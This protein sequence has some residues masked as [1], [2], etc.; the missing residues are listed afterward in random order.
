MRGYKITKLMYGV[1]LFVLD[2]RSGFYK[3]SN[4]ENELM[5]LMDFITANNVVIKEVKTSN[6]NTTWKIGDRVKINDDRR[7]YLITDFDILGNKIVVYGKGQANAE[8]LFEEP[9]E[10]VNIYVEPVRTPVTTP[11][12]ERPVQNAV[13]IDAV[14]RQIEQ[15]NP[16]PIRLRGILKNRRETL[17]QFLVKFFFG[18]GNMERGWNYTKDTVYADDSSVQTDMGKRR[19]LGDIYMICKYYYPNVTLKE[20]LQQLY[21]ELPRYDEQNGINLFRSNKCRQINK[22]VWAGEIGRNYLQTDEPDEYGINRDT[23]LRLLRA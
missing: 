6:G 18:T 21:V 7:I 11:V 22:R 4:D 13:S 15:A 12:A 5:G 20:V 10:N 8:N 9:I 3:N 1:T 2:E 17:Q 16:R 14:Q 23:Y 19:S